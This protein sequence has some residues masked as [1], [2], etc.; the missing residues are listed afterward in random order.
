MAPYYRRLQIFFNWAI[1]LSDTGCLLRHP[2]DPLGFEG[3]ATARGDREIGRRF[4]EGQF[5]TEKAGSVK[6]RICLSGFT[7][8]PKPP[9]RDQ[10]LHFAYRGRELR[11]GLG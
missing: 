2:F 7:S 6:I 4:A 9:D 5:G 8:T 10:G 1:F 11:G 3:G